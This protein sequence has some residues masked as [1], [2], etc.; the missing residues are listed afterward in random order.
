MATKVHPKAYR[1]STIESWESTWF[2]G[3]NLRQ[4]LMEDV[5][6]RAFL[7]KKLRE[8]AVDKIKIDRARNLITVNIFT[9]K[10]GAI[11]GRAGSGIEDLKALIRK[12]FY[13]G[14]RT[15]VQVNVQDVGQGALS[16]PAVAE[17][18]AMDLEK[19]MP[20][21]R[22]MKQAIDK[23]MKAGGLGVRIIV[24]GRLN[25]AEIART[26]RLSHGKVPLQNLRADIQYAQARANTMFGVIGVKVWIYRGEI[27]SGKVPDTFAVQGGRRER[28]DR[29]NT[30][31]NS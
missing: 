27:F 9:S 4:F 19:R 20:F 24:S 17:Q 30:R 8:A 28:D 5:K 12:T 2:A 11:I 1:L 10:P 29:H 16:A 13:R 18:I 25:G 15:N 31:A 14:R 6:I 21:R 22:V 3:K 23:V 7:K 26:E